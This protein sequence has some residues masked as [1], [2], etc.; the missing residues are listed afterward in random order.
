MLEG[1]V[2]RAGRN[3]RPRS[4]CGWRREECL[5]RRPR[6][7]MHKERCIG[8]FSPHLR[9]WE[10]WEGLRWRV[11]KGLRTCMCLIGK[12]AGLGLGF[13][14]CGVVGGR[15]VLVWVTWVLGATHSQLF[16]SQVSCS[17]G[18]QLAS[19]LVSV[20][21]TS[22]QNLV[23]IGQAPPNQWN[24]FT[25][26]IGLG[27]SPFPLP[28][29][30]SVPMA[31]TSYTSRHGFC[32]ASPG[33]ARCKYHSVIVEPCGWH[34]LLSNEGSCTATGGALQVPLLV[35]LLL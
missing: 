31:T 29:R 32:V 8:W 17:A 25:K 27:I 2:Q 10:Q 30:T 9:K 33:H 34:K 7:L 35:T 16:G 5:C 18:Y 21:P 20:H 13:G 26:L 23:L 14:R 12:V 6:H 1:V 22:G 28:E 4:W 19:W 3:L 24:S 11:R 15:W